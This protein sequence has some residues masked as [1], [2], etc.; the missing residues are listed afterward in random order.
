[1]ISSDAVIDFK[2][3]RSVDR[4]S[5]GSHKGLCLP[6]AARRLHSQLISLSAVSL[7]SR[8]CC[9]PLESV[10]SDSFRRPEARASLGTRRRVGRLQL[11]HP[12]HAAGR[13]LLPFTRVVA[14]PWHHPARDCAP[15]D[16]DECRV[17]SG[18]CP[19][20]T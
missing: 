10:G 5:L 16:D 9:W 11:L 4:C 14:C 3:D 1:M 17:S 12:L 20:S 15:I 6:S 19:L 2:I 8:R 7:E 13:S 18:T